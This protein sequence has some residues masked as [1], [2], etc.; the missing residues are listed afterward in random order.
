MGVFLLPKTLCKRI[1]SLI[2]K[3]W[4]GHQHN[5]TKAAW[6]RWDSMGKSKSSN[7]MGF[8]DL[9]VF[10]LAL[11]AKQGW[12][13]VQQPKSMVAT[14]LRDKYYRGGEFMHASLGRNPSYAWKSSFKAREVLERDLVWRVG[15]GNKLGF[16][17]ISGS[18]FL[19]LIRSN[20][21]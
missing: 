1:N 21:L 15:N 17:G 14:I 11:L 20:F 12:G 19:L 5:I 4:W 2:S 6:M 18:Q 10:N 13:L 9:E 3:F 16:G 7:G 8:R